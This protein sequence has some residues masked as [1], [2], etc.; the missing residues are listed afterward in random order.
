MSKYMV[1]IRIPSRRGLL[2]PIPE[3]I[4]I[5]D[6]E[7]DDIDKYV[8]S[9]LKVPLSAVAYVIPAEAIRTVTPKIVYDIHPE[10]SR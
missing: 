3:K 1:I 2:S 9:E 4:V 7:T 8:S 10:W 5:S 6:I